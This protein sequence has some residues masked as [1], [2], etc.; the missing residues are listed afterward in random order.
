[1]TD[2]F[3]ALTVA[4]DV[5]PTHT[6]PLAGL[7]FVVKENIDVEGC[8][9]TNGHPEFAASHAPAR[10]HAPVVETLLAAG[11]R[12]VGK[13]QMDEMA[14]SLLG[15]NAHYGTPVNP[16][17]R[18]RHPGG[19]SSG[20]AVA[21]AAGLA[22]FALG[23]DTAGSCRAPA[24]FCGVFGFRPS[25]GALSLDGVVPLAPSFDV[26]G[27]FARDAATLE[28][29]GDVLLPQDSDRRPLARSQFLTDAFADCPQ[30]EA[31]RLAAAVVAL[32]PELPMREVA[33]EASFWPEALAHF[34]N[35][36]AFEAHRSHGAW[37][38][39][40][41]PRLGPGIAERFA[42]AATVTDAQRQEAGAFRDG[43]RPKIE[44]LFGDDGVLVLPTTPFCSPRLDESPEALDAKRYQMFRLFLLAS[45]FGLP[46]VSLP[47]P[48]DPPLGLSLI[49]RRG[50][51]RALLA[52]A[53]RVA[54][55]VCGPDANS[56]ART[57]S[58][59][60]TR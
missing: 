15:A 28:R 48:S 32:A 2:D 42:Y 55:R 29:I 9:S 25:H 30:T 35:Y 27:F 26:V 4:L 8:V 18:D 1:M 41:R 58:T 38:E 21:V 33:L 49:G 59:G 7:T 31:A 46:Q 16:R 47:L 12:L 10:A 50:T 51:D 24:A 5:R 22:D 53:S 3:G 54:R 17:A 34:R 40:R 13:S 39:S 52:L 14:Y 43:A 57:P 56:D 45:Y 11:A 23:T 37:I 6:G 19:S 36:Q 20:S 60:I 44:A